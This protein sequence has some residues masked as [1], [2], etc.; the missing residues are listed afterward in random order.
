MVVRPIEVRYWGS[1][2]Q[3]ANY[4]WT[5]DDTNTAWDGCPKHSIV[6]PPFLWYAAPMWHRWEASGG[7]AGDEPPGWFKEMLGMRDRIISM[8]RDETRDAAIREL[9]RTM[10]GNLYYLGG[11]MDP[12]EANFALVKNNFMNVPDPLANL[13]C[14]HPST[15]YFKEGKNSGELERA[16]RTT[17]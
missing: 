17:P 3:A 5:V 2:L 1:M 16:A 15:F 12:P 4:D 8:P 10:V 6:V 11:I 13:V 14:V 9:I 7:R